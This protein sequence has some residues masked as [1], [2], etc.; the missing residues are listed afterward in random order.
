M[1]KT[2]FF[3]FF[4]LAFIQFAIFD[5]YAQWYSIENGTSGKIRQIKFKDEITGWYTDDA[6]QIYKT[7]D[8]SITW[9]CIDIRYIDSL[10]TLYPIIN[11]GDTVLISAFRNRLLRSVNGGLNWSVVPISSFQN[12][13]ISYFAYLKRDLIYAILYKNDG[14]NC[15]LIKSTN[16]GLNW[17]TI[18]DF[19]YFNSEPRCLNFLN[20]S[21]GFIKLHNK[22]IKT[23]NFGYNWFIIFNDSGTTTNQFDYMKF[24]NVNLGFLLKD[25]YHLYRTTNGGYNWQPLDLNSNIISQIEFVND[26]IGYM[27]ESFSN[28]IFYKTTN[29][30][31]N[32]NV[33]YSNTSREFTDFEIKNNIIYLNGSVGGSVLKST[34]GGYN[35]TDFSFYNSN[36]SFLTISFPNSQTGYIGTSNMFLLKTT[37]SGS[38]WFPSDVYHNPLLGNYGISKIQFLNEHTGWF[39]APDTGLFKTTNSGNNWRYFSTNVYMPK[40][41]FFSNLNTGWVAIDSFIVPRAHTF[42]YKTTNGGNNFILNNMFNVNSVTDMIFYDSLYGYIGFDEYGQTQNLYRTTNGGE[43]WQGID[44]DGVSK[45]C[46]IDKKIAF[47]GLL[48][49]YSGSKGL[50]KTND[51]GDNWHVV[52][53]TNSIV[54]GIKF[55]NNNIGFVTADS[56]NIYYTLN[57]GDNWN[58]SY[59]GS[60]VG[61]SDVSFLSNHVALAIGGNGKIYRTD[62]LGGIIGISNISSELPSKYKLFQNYPN[63]FNSTTKIKYQLNTDTRIHK[64]RVKI[65][66]YDILGELISTLVNDKQSPGNYETEFKGDNLASGIYFYM[67]SIDGV[68][69]ETKKMILLK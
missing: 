18:S 36:A 19:S 37:N 57:G 9:K 44:F 59:I 28:S 22:I 45:I 61:L 33:I 65:N 66:V 32:W 30:G 56:K 50:Y 58:Y 11:S 3:I 43:S 12:C 63:P 69:I 25:L 14:N 29:S 7:T 20:D 38:N 48:P 49:Q 15:N 52:L 39:I 34:N 4:I 64:P 6:G 17:S 55:Y 26:S 2:F 46:I 21:V 67:L 54:R 24:A 23:T 16:F 60:C 53:T 41:F 31:L 27:S 35:W 51:G 47:A 62:N 40:I 13:G 5:S 1:N 68:N 10:S 42:L 8:G